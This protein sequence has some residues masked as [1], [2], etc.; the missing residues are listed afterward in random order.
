MSGSS[1]SVGKTIQLN[2]QISTLF[3]Y[4]IGYACLIS[5]CLANAA[6][7]DD[8]SA[9]VFRMGGVSA[10]PGMS[11]VEKSNNN[12][13]SSNINKQSSL[14]S[15]SSPSVL[16]QARKG[17]D[18]YLLSYRA[19]VGRYKNSPADN[20][21]DHS[22]SVAAELNGSTSANGKLDLEHK[23]GHDDRGSTF[24]PGTL[25]PNTWSSTGITG[26]FIYG[27]EEARGK[28]LLDAGFQNRKYKNNRVVTTAYD[29]TLR[30]M[31]AAF[32]FRVLPKTFV[33]FQ[34]SDTRIVYKDV[35]STLNGNE[36]RYLLGATWDVTTQTSGTIKIGHLQKKFDSAM[37]PT[38][39]G[40]SWE[41]SV[42][43]TPLESAQV[44]LVSGR[45]PSESTGVGNFLLIT[46]HALDFGYDMSESASL[47]FNAGKTSEEFKG[48]V[49][50]DSTRSYGLKAEYKVRSWLVGALEYN[51]ASK[52]STDSTAYY[53]RNVVA[54]SVHFGL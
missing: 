52:T 34:T 32:H 3:K 31:S 2:M 6:V 8:P 33:I 18:A 17:A 54:V 4:A 21:V 42:R 25:E 22:Y 15:V 45:K 49:R 7:R 35:A 1:K 44:S 12:I 46:N 51:V 40:A 5:A 11:L 38:F 43:W 50:T 19:D 27:A 53:D 16:L 28:V 37:H 23:I 41:G 10:Y 20:Y 14:V 9:P 29:K 26:A 36:R 24:G 13:F 39:K 30:D 47:H 48:V